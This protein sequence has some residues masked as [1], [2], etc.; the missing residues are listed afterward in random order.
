VVQLA[1]DTGNSCFE[2]EGQDGTPL[3]VCLNPVG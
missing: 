1:A 2:P 3:A